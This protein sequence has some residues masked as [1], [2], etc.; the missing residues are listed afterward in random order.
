[1]HS[2]LPNSLYFY[3]I[4]RNHYFFIV[5]YAMILLTR[6]GGFSRSKIIKP[7]PWVNTKEIAEHMGVTVETV[8]KWIRLEKIPCHR[9][10]KLWKFK[11]SEV[12]E[13][14]TSGQ[15]IE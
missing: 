2:P 9:I 15:A 3:Q 13:W 6:N 14:V 5:I 8:R 4:M 11:V 10:G 7:E 1:M 12:D